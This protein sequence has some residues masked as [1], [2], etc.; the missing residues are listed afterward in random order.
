MAE[1]LWINVHYNQNGDLDGQPSHADYGEAIIYADEDANYVFTI[2]YNEGKVA[3]VDLTDAIRAYHA[4][5]ALERR[6]E[7]EFSG[8]L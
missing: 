5:V 4:E 8:A 7:L 3:V 2:H 6:H 1:E